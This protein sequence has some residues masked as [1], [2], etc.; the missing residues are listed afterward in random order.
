MT[1]LSRAVLILFL[2]V[3]GFGCSSSQTME[4]QNV[5]EIAPKPGPPAEYAGYT[6]PFTGD[7]NAVVEGEK[8]YRERCESCHG[9]DGRGDGPLAPSL[10]PKPG[11][12]VEGGLSDQYLFWRISE[13]GLMEPFNSVMPAWKMILNEDQIGQII[14][15]IRSVE[16]K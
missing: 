15:F 16:V 8:I 1:Y 6:N 11:S 3:S 2:L 12:L 4:E 13:G 10:N 7:P 9:E 14:A 5:S